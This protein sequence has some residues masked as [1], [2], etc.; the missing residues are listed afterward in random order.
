MKVPLLDLKAQYRRIRSEVR[1][2]IDEVLES[3]QFILGA[4][5]QRFEEEAAS[6]LQCDA[7]IGVASGSD[8]LLL[9]LMALG[10]RA[11]DAVLVPPLTFFS[12][13]SS[14]TRLSATPIFIDIDPESYL[15]D[16]KKVE[17]LQTPP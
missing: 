10:I 6:Y 14:I 12:T 3:Q 2:V 5:V 16:P 4:T 17:A 9:S 15:M 8:A 11:G 7:A 1:H 13:V